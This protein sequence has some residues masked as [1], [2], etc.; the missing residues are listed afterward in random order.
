MKAFFNFMSIC[1][2]VTNTCLIFVFLILKNMGLIV[3]DATKDNFLPYVIFL[4]L[5]VITAIIGITSAIFGLK[6][7]YLKCE[8]FGIII[9]IMNVISLITVILMGVDF[10]A[11][12]IPVI[13]FAIYV[14]LARKL[15][16][17][18]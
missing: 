13:S 9:L 16:L 3:L 5:C 11:S 4:S 18:E 15:R 2:I 17:T 10:K 1:I 12:L 8:K 6:G 14:F 7:E